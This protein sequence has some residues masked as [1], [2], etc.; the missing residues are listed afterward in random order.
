MMDR[1]M[2]EVTAT[3]SGDW[4][5]IDVPGLLGAHT[6]A[7]RLD[8]VEHMARELIGLLLDVPEDSFDV[9]VQ[10]ELV[11]EWARLLRETR[12]ARTAADEA[13]ERAQRLVRTAVV[14]LQGAGLSTR[15]VGQLLGVTHQRV[16]QLAAHASRAGTNA[17][18]R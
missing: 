6:Q 10:A 3:R 14:T 5:A 2:Y 13:S 7:R 1:T 4:W 17:A 18:K 15:E 16:Q 9:N 11:D 8:Q 12:E